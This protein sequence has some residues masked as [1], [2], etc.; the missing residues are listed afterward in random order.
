MRI[1]ELQPNKLIMKRRHYTPPTVAALDLS[2]ERGF[3]LSG[4][5][6]TIEDWDHE[7]F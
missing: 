5:N 3:A 7:N 6:T 1:T 2:V 4:H